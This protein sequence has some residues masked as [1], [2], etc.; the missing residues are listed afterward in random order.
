M[1]P[2]RTGRPTIVVDADIPYV[3]PVLG[4]IGRLI[5]VPGHRIGRGH[6][7]KADA[8]VVRS[9]TGVN[10]ELLDGSRIRFVGSATSGVDHVDVDWLEEHDIAFADAA[11]ANADSVVEYVLSSIA[12]GLGTSET[13]LDE[14]ALGVVGCGR[15]GGR[16]AER[17][18]AL[19]M[20]VLRNDPPRVRSGDTAPDTSFIQ[21]DAL[22]Q[23]ADIV[24]I[25]V[26]LVRT[27]R[28]CTVDLIG[29]ASIDRMKPGAWLIQSSRG[30]TVDE[31]AA[32]RARQEGRL[33]FLV[34]D[35]FS[36][37]PVPDA[38]SIR[39]ADIATPHIAGYSRD[40]KLEGVLRIRDA[41]VTSLDLRTEH[42]YVHPADLPDPSAFI[43]GTSHGSDPTAVFRD[44]VPRMYDVTTDDSRFRRAWFGTLAEAAA[45]GDRAEAFHRLRATCPPRWSFT[46]YSLDEVPDGV[47]PS[48]L[49]DGIGVGTVHVR[50]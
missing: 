12:A 11:G 16:L 49:T 36:G 32:V 40:A 43:L 30:G 47:A 38:G 25:H 22:L 18:E 31:H 28:D 41:L 20:H 8:L 21:L 33:G 7:R 6:V 4:P 9:V 42:E 10:A 24:S 15:V 27:G 29:E 13:R 23:G 5:P 2:D 26:P 14:I 3:N 19:G 35:V 34:L 48:F 45:A 37:E 46:R 1:I 50:T 44:I 17:A 39:T